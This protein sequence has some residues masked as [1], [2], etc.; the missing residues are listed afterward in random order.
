[1]QKCRTGNLSNYHEGCS[2]ELW[3]K[4]CA[5]AN[6]QGWTGGDYK[7]L[8]L[9][10]ERQMES[11]PLNIRERMAGAI[12]DFTYDLLVNV[13]NAKDTA[14]I[15]IE[16]L[17]SKGFDPGLKAT[18]IENPEEWTMQRWIETEV[19]KQAVPWNLGIFFGRLVVCRLPVLFENL[20]WCNPLEA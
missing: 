19:L 8:N 12:E 18:S 9:P 10:F 20:S 1:M 6:E 3:D 7:K 17:C 16:L 14:D 2:E 11:L 4:M 13:F 15:A 5:Y